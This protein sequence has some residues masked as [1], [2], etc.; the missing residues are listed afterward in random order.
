MIERP[1]RYLEEFVAAGSDRLTVH[2][3]ACSNLR[4]V[5]ESIGELGADAGVVINPETEVS[6]IEYIVD[7]VDSVLEMSVNPGFSGQE[8][9]PSTVEKIER[10]RAVGDVEIAVDGGWCRD[11]S[12]ACRQRRRHS[13]RRFRP[14]RSR[15]YFTA[16]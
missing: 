16:A 10:L 1:E 9:I 13:R 8:F 14:V 6:E 5:I 4:T 12:P 15:R 7:D 3:E 2:A 11:R